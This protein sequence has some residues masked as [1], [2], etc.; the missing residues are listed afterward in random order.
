[1]LLSIYNYIA[2]W[3]REQIREI[4]FPFMIAGGVGAILSIPAVLP[5]AY[6]KLFKSD[7]VF[8]AEIA[9]GIHRLQMTGKAQALP[10]LGRPR[11]G[12]GWCASSIK[13]SQH[14]WLKLSP[15]HASPPL[16]PSLFDV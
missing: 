2:G 14:P 16:S 12:W 11:T 15:P 13:P 9:K 7:Q 5:L 10:P 3:L 8:D 6:S 4:E 1:M